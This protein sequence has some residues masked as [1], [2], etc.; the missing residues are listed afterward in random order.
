MTSLC[1]VLRLHLPPALRH[2]TFF[3]IGA[4]ATYED[5]AANRA[6]AA[7]AAEQCLPANRLLLELLRA[8]QGA[9]RLALSVSGTALDLLQA[10]APAVLESFRRLAS[11][12]CVEFL[13][14]PY[15]HSLAHLFSPAEFAEQVALHRRRIRALFGQ[16]GATFHNT[17]FLGGAALARSVEALGFEAMLA[18]AAPCAPGRR[19][20][21]NVYRPRGCRTL[22]LLLRDPRAPGRPV[23][24]HPVPG[25][26]PS[27]ALARWLATFRRSDATAILVLDYRALGS[28]RGGEPLALDFLRALPATVLRNASFRFQTPAEAALTHAPAAMPG[29]GPEGRG[30]TPAED[31]R[32]RP[33]GPAR[34]GGLLPLEARPWLG[35]ELQRD[36]ARSLYALED[37]VRHCGSRARLDDWRRLQDAEHFRR[38]GTAGPGRPSPYEAYIDFMNM[39]ADLKARIGKRR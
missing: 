26:R 11:T 37:A 15:H 13:H 1:C 33:R 17:E 38:M 32:L 3:D 21:N 25:T 36:A 6:A 14:L 35:N 18:D 27:P 29:C 28:P 5:A 16:A 30:R 39:L 9:F 24:A 23:L 34:P 4:S 7:G 20:P 31:R 12:G 2:Y 19:R 10:H 22:C 8:H